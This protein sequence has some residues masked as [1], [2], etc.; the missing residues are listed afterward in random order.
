MTTAD[1][2]DA[3]IK[4]LEEENASLKT[5]LLQYTSMNSE[6]DS[7][8][9]DDSDVTFQDLFNIEEIQ[10]IQDSFSQAVGISSLITAP[11]GT[12][13]TRPGNFCRLCR[14]IIRNTEKGLENCKKSDRIIGAYRP[15]GPTVQPC[16]SSGLYDAGA[17]IRAGNKHIA[18]WLIGQVRTEVQDE[19]QLASYALDIGADPAAYIEALS[20]VPVMPLEQFTRIANSLYLF[21][22]LLSDLALQN[23]KQKKDIYRL[24]GMLPICASCKKIRDDKGYWNSIETY[25]EK[26]SGAVFSHG[27]CPDCVKKLYGNEK[28][29]KEQ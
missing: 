13:I 9:G 19:K 6:T 16:L 11:D 23:L 20:E 8:S 26:H 1:E 29:F 18:N 24:S 7:Y 3:R 25:I 12:P 22:N 17:S 14:D 21:A 5:R 2:I 10:A 4:V 28:W 15:D 27:L